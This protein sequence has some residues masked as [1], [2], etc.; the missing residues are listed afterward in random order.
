MNLKHIIKREKADTKGYIIY[1]SIYMKFLEI[2]NLQKP[3]PNQWLPGTGGGSGD[4]LH[5]SSRELFAIT[6]MF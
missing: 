5:M 4:L 6:E 3:K 2:A 1:D